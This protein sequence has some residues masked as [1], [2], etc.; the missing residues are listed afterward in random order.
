MRSRREAEGNDGSQYLVNPMGSHACFVLCSLKKAT[1][2]H[3]K[4]LVYI[5]SVPQP[6]KESDGTDADVYRKLSD[7]DLHRFPRR[8]KSSSICF[9]S[10]FQ[11]PICMFCMQMSSM[12]M[13]LC[14]ESMPRKLISGILGSIRALSDSLLFAT[15]SFDDNDKRSF[16]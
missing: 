9:L 6:D 15:F 14:M 13:W 7:L 8:F 16:A 10:G 11:N 12:P 1:R 5:Y 2:P 3:W 4:I